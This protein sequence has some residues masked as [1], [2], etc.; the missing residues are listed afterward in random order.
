MNTSA[1]AP[2]RPQVEAFLSS[3]LP[4]WFGEGLDEGQGMFVEALS[5]DGQ[6][7]RELPRRAR[8]QARQ[9][10]VLG[11]A[12]ERGEF[13]GSAQHHAEL[14]ERV[15]ESVTRLYGAPGGGFY[16]LVGAEGQVLDAERVLYDQAFYL[17]ALAWLYHVTGKATYR[18]D[19]GRLW[20]FIETLRDPH[21]GGFQ[22]SDTPKP[23]PRQ[24]NPHMHLFEACLLCAELLGKVPWLA[25]ADELYTLFQTRF[26]DTTT[27]PQPFL[28]EF[29]TADW[30]PDPAC[31][32]HLDPGHHYEWTW[33]LGRY[34][35]LGGA[36]VP[37]L[38]LLYTV[39]RTWGTDRDGLAYDEIGPQG[40]ELR[41]TKRLWV[42]CEV[43]K[44]HLAYGRW[45]GDSE[46]LERAGHVLQGILT[47]YLTPQG[48]WA[49]QL[50][51]DRRNISEHSPSSTL[52]HLYV[53]LNEA[54]PVLAATP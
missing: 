33:L 39:A 46:A 21:N 23:V 16:T 48:T 9:L 15:M 49:D 36:A 18:N 34:R 5:F 3:A 42:Q 17:M 32:D 37:E 25:R 44:G 53:A 24:Q 10:Y 11:L 40:R 54:L 4:L 29:F 8:V 41:S 52:Y 26:L 2:L 38:P 31:G 6:P 1:L 51:R 7:L 14:M 22:L 19:A 47:H 27:G 50:S 13:V 28:R 20:A 45:S 43:L 30:Q 12:Y 35:V